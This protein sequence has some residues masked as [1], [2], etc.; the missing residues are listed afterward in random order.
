M[1]TRRSFFLLGF[2]LVAGLSAKARVVSAASF[3]AD[4]DFDESLPRNEDV[5]ISPIYRKQLVPYRVVGHAGAIV[6]NPRQYFLYQVRSD[7][8]AIRY[9]IGVGRAGFEWKG[10]ARIMRKKRWPNWY[11]PSEMRKRQPYLPR[12]MPGGLKNPLGARALYLYQGKVDTIYRIHGSME[13]DSIGTSVSSG[14]IRMLNEHVID[15]YGRVPI[16]TRVIVL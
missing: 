11:P 1:W 5:A 8:S 13:P 2:G 14:C 10:E 12:M 4:A 7:M 16:G 6:I 15:L 3:S 9:G